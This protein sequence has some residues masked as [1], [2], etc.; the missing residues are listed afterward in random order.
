[1]RATGAGVSHSRPD[2]VLRLLTAATFDLPDVRLPVAP[3][4]RMRLPCRMPSSRPL[5][6][7]ASVRFHVVVAF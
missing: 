6:E 7:S 2:N 4:A 3:A 5:L 1:M